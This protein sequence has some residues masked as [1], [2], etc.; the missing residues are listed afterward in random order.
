MIVLQY[1]LP[2][3]EVGHF[4][5]KGKAT[6]WFVEQ[7]IG[8]YNEMVAIDTVPSMHSAL[9]QQ[10][11]T[12]QPDATNNLMLMCCLPAGLTLMPCHGAVCHRWN[13]ILVNRCYCK[14]KPAVPHKAVAEVS[15]I[16]N[17]EERLVVVNH[18]WQSEST[19]GPKGGWSCVFWSGCNGCS[20]HLVG[21]L[22]HNCWM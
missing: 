6:P 18:G 5:Y 1:Y 15:K 21:H 16:G 19:D 11:S 17:L 14:Y 20:G 7:V 22:T 4:C 9:G 12:K 8:M 3:K 10:K 13:Y 2:L